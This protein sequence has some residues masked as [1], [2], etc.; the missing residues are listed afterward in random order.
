MEKNKAMD[1]NLEIKKIKLTM[2]DLS[3]SLQ[4]REKLLRFGSSSLSDAELLA[5]I[6]R[7]GNREE[8]VLEM[9]ERLL[10]DLSKKDRQS[11]GLNALRNAN[12]ED[13]LSIKGIGQSKATQLLAI[14]EMAKRI[15]QIREIDLEQITSPSK[16]AKI[17]MNELRHE[18]TE[19]FYVV[20]LDTKKRIQFVDKISKGT[21]DATIV[22]PREVFQKS[23]SR[24]AHCIMLLHNHPTGVVKPSKEDIRLTERM[25]EV[26]EIVGIPVID[27]II[28]GD[29]VYFSFLEEGMI[30]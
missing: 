24:R 27:H 17:F 12:L 3:K 13:F 7:T 4:P 26:G 11:A 16:A 8:T 23:I 6:L 5:I 25:R 28:I 1:D 21:L 10:F 22:H 19:E 2:K 20:G 30:V 18:Y 14:M 15:N 9:C 29:G